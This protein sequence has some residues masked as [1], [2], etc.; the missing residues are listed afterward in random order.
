MGNIAKNTPKSLLPVAGRPV[1]EHI[2]K[3]VRDIGIKEIFISTNAKFENNFNSWL[4]GSFF[5][6]VKLL[7]EPAMK[8]GEKLGSIGA[9]Q[10][11]IDKEGTDDDLMVING[12]N[13]FE[14]NLANMVSFYKDKQ[15]FV[16]GTYDTRSVDEAKKLGVVLCDQ[17]GLVMNFEEKPDHPK[18][19]RVSTGIYIFPQPL[20]VK[21]KEYINS[22]NNADRMGD[23]LIWLMKE[24]SLHSFIFSEKWFDIGSPETYQVAQDEFSGD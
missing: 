20:L 18:S 16:F 7:I 11:F 19:S 1:I 8:E 10:Y 24:Q 5:G 14:F 12:D 3:R 2:L 21:I 17:N 22:G 6:D 15:T 13:L 9:L 23:F 4:E